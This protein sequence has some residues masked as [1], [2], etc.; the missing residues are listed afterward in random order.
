MPTA[1]TSSGTTFGVCFRI[2]LGSYHFSRH[3][4]SCFPFTTRPFGTSTTHSISTTRCR[5]TS[6]RPSTQRA[7][8]SRCG[9]R[10]AHSRRV[11]RVH[12]FFIF[13]TFTVRRC[14]AQ[15]TI[16]RTALPVVLLLVPL[17]TFL[18]AG[19]PDLLPM[20]KAVVVLVDRADVLCAVG[21]QQ[22][23]SWADPD[24]EYYSRKRTGWSGGAVTRRTECND[25]GVLRL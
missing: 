15:L 3:G 24:R 14:H 17:A 19:D 12:R 18:F 20:E 6:S 11:C 25:F 9:P 21:N 8:Q 5:R 2:S 4:L 23:G 1:R 10:L 7:P 16:R 22:N 13:S